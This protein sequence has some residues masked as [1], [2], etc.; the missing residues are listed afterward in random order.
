MLKLL[1]I[2]R[3]LIDG[4]LVKFF[5]GL[6]MRLFV[7]LSC[8]FVLDMVKILKGVEFLVCFDVVLGL[9]CVFEKILKGLVKLRILMFLKRK[10]LMEWCCG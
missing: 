5:C 8:F 2:R 6:M 3:M 9:R 4:V 7:V 10:M 1:G